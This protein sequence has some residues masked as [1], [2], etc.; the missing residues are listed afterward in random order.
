MACRC[1]NNALKTLLLPTAKAAGGVFKVE[2]A[3]L[4][5]SYLWL[6]FWTLGVDPSVETSRVR[7][8]EG[9]GAFEGAC[10][11]GRVHQTVSLG[12]KEGVPQTQR[13][14][15]LRE[16]VPHHSLHQTSSESLSLSVSCE[17]RVGPKHQRRPEAGGCQLPKFFVGHVH[18]V[19]DSLVVPVGGL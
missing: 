11:R 7:A 19:P 2:L 12:E 13:R 14:C 9:E 4:F 3:L 18:T 5:S 8:V 6:R 16:G 1:E 15:C 17:W 10:V